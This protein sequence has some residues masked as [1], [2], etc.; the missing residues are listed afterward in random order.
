MQPGI[1]SN[2]IVYYYLILVLVIT[3]I[4]IL[5]RI[6]DS[7]FGLILRCV[8]QN[9]NRVRFLGRRVRKNQLRIYIT[10]SF[11]AALAGA[12]MRRRGQFHPHG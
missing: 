3:S 1:F 12:L 4:W 11:F 2:P 8:N 9:P 7:P 5:K 10:A 6:A